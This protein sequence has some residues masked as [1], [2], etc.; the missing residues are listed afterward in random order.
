M[1]SFEPPTQLNVLCYKF[2]GVCMSVLWHGSSQTDELIFFSIED[3]SIVIAAMY[4]LRKYI[5]D[6]SKRI[7]RVDGF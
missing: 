5:H 2:D 1:K 4:D 6:V 7:L 3:D